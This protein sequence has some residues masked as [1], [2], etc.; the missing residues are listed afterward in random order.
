MKMPVPKRGKEYQEWTDRNVPDDQELVYGRCEYYSRLMKER[1]PELRLAKGRYITQ[2]RK[3]P[4][5]WLIDPEGCIVDCTEHQF[6]NTGE[7][8]EREGEE[9]VGK[10]INCGEL[11]YRSKYN[12]NH[13]CSKE[14]HDEEMDYLN[15]PE[16]YPKGVK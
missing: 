10:C 1:F 15:N 9:P 12:G 16:K 8:V 7:H 6:K 4:H 2:T 11:I 13:F 14:C 5:W 3:H